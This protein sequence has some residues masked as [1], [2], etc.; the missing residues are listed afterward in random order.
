ML[1]PFAV[2]I[3]MLAHPAWD[4][5]S[6][7]R[8]EEA[9]LAQERTR[10]GARLEEQAREVDALKARGDSQGPKLQAALAA[11]QE[12]ARRLQALDGQL[13]AKRREVVA[14]ADR[15]V[16]EERDAQLRAQAVAARADAA[17]ALAAPARPS[18]VAAA[19]GVSESATDGPDDLRAKADLL[20]DTFDKVRRELVVL[21]KK[22]AGA[23]RRADLQRASRSLDSNVFFE[24]TRRQRA[25]RQSAQT[26]GGTD[27][28]HGGTANTPTP[29]TGAGD[30][31]SGFTT[32]G[33]ATTATSSAPPLDVIVLKDVLD[34]TTL[35]DLSQSHDSARY[36]RALDRA[37]QRLREIAADLDQRSHTLRKRADELRR[38]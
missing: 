12:L 16:A 29:G 6:R 31:D 15:V 8:T 18:A 30:H 22:Y 14:A 26:L 2:A 24:D 38:K 17:R 9:Q 19:L 13:G 7:V 4:Q 37:R 10:L 21:D 36:L 25:E 3:L 20:A 5:L 28:A 1:R 33:A 23:Q 32:P 34:P 11:A 35:A 27:T